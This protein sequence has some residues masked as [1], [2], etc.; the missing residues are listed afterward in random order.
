[1]T[2]Y[3]QILN[4]NYHLN[5]ISVDD[6]VHRNSFIGHAENTMLILIPRSHECVLK[7][8]RLH[9]AKKSGTVFLYTRISFHLDSYLLIY[10][11]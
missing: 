11:F 3:Q 1:M 9:L 2:S 4:K 7:S 10:A 5:V 8:L 6:A